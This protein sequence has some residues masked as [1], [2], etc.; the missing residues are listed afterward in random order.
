MYQ[1]YFFFSKYAQMGDILKVSVN[2]FLSQRGLIHTC[3]NFDYILYI[4]CETC[5][6]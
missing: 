2:D 4:V 3:I 6:F 1:D 5:M